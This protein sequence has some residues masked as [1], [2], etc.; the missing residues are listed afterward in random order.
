[1]LS[2]LNITDSC[3]FG[4]IDDI[5]TSGDLIESEGGTIRYKI[6]TKRQFLPGEY[7][8]HIV[9]DNKIAIVCHEQVDPEKIDKLLKRSDVMGNCSNFLSRY[10]WMHYRNWRSPNNDRF[11]KHGGKL[12]KKIKEQF[13]GS[14]NDDNWTICALV[15]FVAHEN[16]NDVENI[17]FI[18]EK[19]NDYVYIMR[20]MHSGDSE[21]KI[22]GYIINSIPDG[23]NGKQSMILGDWH[24]GNLLVDST[25]EKCFAFVFGDFYACQVLS[26]DLSKLYKHDEIEDICSK[27]FTYDIKQFLLE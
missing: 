14:R 21:K 19:Q 11:M 17:N 2:K 9:N 12:F 27:N 3:V 13:H 26:C 16:M 25:S 15:F 1:M 4:D 7:Q 6:Q 24:Y 5:F 10:D 20:Q 22:L 8:I 23:Q 18:I